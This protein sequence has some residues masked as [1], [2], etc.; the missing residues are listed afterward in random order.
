MKKYFLFLLIGFTI[1]KPAFSTS[2]IQWFR[3]SIVLNNSCEVL[4]GKISIDE[5]YDM[6]LFKEGDQILVLNAHRLQALYFYDSIANINRKFVSLKRQTGQRV[7]H[8]LFEA[9]VSGEVKVLRKL[10]SYHGTSRSDSDDYSY[11]VQWDEHLE[12]LQFFKERVYADLLIKAGNDMEFYET[13]NHLNPNHPAD[14]VMLIIQFNLIMKNKNH[15]AIAT[16]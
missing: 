16:R 8:R 13:E 4:T 6:V 3:G 2:S 7:E 1:C 12:P 10:K 14:A 9:V 5:T 11:Y 15:V